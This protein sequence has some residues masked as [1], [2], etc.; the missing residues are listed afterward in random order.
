MA[1]RLSDEALD[2]ISRSGRS[3]NGYTERPPFE[4]VNRIV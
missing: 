2:T 3:Y 1:A 4:T